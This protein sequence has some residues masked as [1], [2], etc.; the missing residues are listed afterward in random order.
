MTEDASVKDKATQSAQ[1][2]KDAA[3]DL[4]STAAD[5]AQD[6]AQEAKYQARDLMGQAR[7]QLRSQASDQ[8]RNAVSN[9]RSLGDELDSM[10][11]STQYSGKSGLA[12][13]LVSQAAGHAH[14]VA[15]WLD[16]RNPEELL[17][18]VRRFARR[19]PGAFLLGALAAGVVAGRLTRGVVAEHTDSGSDAGDSAGY[20][21]PSYG[22]PGYTT[23]GYGTTGTAGTTTGTTPGAYST[24]TYTTPETQVPSSTEAWR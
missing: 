9:L 11:N 13:D 17:D 2:G 22:T 5:K 4:A 23:P 8:H 16:G 15:D 19:R 24:P 6:V 20:A 3:S 10:A 18:E 14:G 12:T 7:G 1:V 21:V